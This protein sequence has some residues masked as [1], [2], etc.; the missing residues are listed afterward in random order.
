[1][2]GA[3][4]LAPSTK[5]RLVFDGAGDFEAGSY[6]GRNLHFGVREHAMG[7]VLNGLSLSKVRAFGSGFFIFSDYG[8]PSLRLA[9]LMEIPVLYVFTHDSIGLGED[10]PTHQPV[11]H[12]ASLRAI[13]GLVTIRPADANEVIEAW[14]AALELDHT[15]VALVLS[16]QAVP[17]LDRKRHGAAS[18]TRKGAYVLRDTKSKPQVILIGTGSEVHLCLEAAAELERRG[19]AGR[20]VSMPSWELFER[21]SQRYRDAV[22]PPEIRAR[23]SVEQAS[24]FGWE[25]WVG[26]SGAR[27]GM[28]TF[29]ASAPL[30]DLLKKFG[31]TVDH[32]VRAALDQLG[33]GSG[34]TRGAP[35]SASRGAQTRG[36]GRHPG[37]KRPATKRTTPAR[38]RRLR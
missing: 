4:D 11:E 36:T 5:T 24:T 20:V 25:R 37:A 3:A 32:V 12:L 21:Q 18:G 19:I 1:M 8:R 9:A 14:K 28:H 23:V 15:P 26:A 35:R 33:S 38:G 29:G 30:A 7:A 31:F 2:G 10:G 22:L 13:P 6:G 27:V 17:T 16:R 34:R